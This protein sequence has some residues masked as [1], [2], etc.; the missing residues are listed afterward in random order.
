MF[1]DGST[2]RD[3]TYIDDIVQGVIAA[4]DYSSSPFEIINL[5]NS[6]SVTLKNLITQLEKIT[7]KKANI[8]Q[9]P[10]QPGDLHKTCADISKAKRLLQYNPSTTLE[11]GL[12]HFYDWYQQHEAVLNLD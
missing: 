10:E 9:Q 12:R 8:T 7:G 5:G 3:Y 11:D 1:G 4:I 6:E 2:S